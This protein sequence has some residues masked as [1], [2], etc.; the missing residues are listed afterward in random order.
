[1]WFWVLINDK[2]SLGGGRGK[3][4]IFDHFKNHFKS[5]S[6]SRSTREKLTFPNIEDNNAANLIVPF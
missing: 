5:K 3:G 1:M 6:L 2:R 4:E